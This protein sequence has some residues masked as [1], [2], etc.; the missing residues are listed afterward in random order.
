MRLFRSDLNVE[1]QSSARTF[2]AWLLDV[3]DGNIGDPDE[4]D[5]TD[6]SWVEIPSRYCIEDDEEGL[7]NMIDFIYDQP[8]L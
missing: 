2:A 5:N 8:T 4:E 6:S 1:E 7:S 3:G